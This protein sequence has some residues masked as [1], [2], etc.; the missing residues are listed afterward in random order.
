VLAD[1]AVRDADAFAA[2]AEVAKAEAAKIDAARA[3]VVK[4]AK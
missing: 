3:E 1:L 2:I 4:T